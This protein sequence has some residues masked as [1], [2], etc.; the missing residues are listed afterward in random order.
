MLP[1]AESRTLYDTWRERLFKSPVQPLGAM[2][3][4]VSAQEPIPVEARACFETGKV[5]NS[6]G[7]AGQGDEACQVRGVKWRLQLA[8]DTLILPTLCT[9]AM[10]LTVP[11]PAHS[12]PPEAQQWLMPK[13][14]GVDR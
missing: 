4:A 5:P 14:H 8:L 1:C 3:S 2:P 7:S 11:S 10:C 9:D 6:P 12:G 13:Y